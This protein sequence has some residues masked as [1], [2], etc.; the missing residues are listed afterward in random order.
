MEVP[1]G[2]DLKGKKKE[3]CLKLRNN[4]YG[5]KQAGRVW[6]KHLNKGLTKLGFKVS[7]VDPCVYYH[8]HAVFMLY[9][10]DGIFAGPSKSEIAMLIKRMQAEFTVT[11]EGDIKEY[12]GVLVERQSDGTLK[13]SQPQ[14]I[15]QILED[16][17][18]NSRTKSKPTPAPGGQLLEREIDSEA[19]ED[20]FHYRSVIG[21]ANFLEKSTRLDIAVAVHQC[22]RFSSEPKQSHADAVRYFGRYLQGTQDEGLILDPKNDKL[23][24]CWVNA[25]FLGQYVK[26]AQDLALDSMTAKSRTGFIITYA[27]CPITWGSR[28]QQKAT[29]SSTESEYVALSEAFRVLLPMMDLLEEAVAQGVPVELGPPVIHCKAFEDNSGALQ[30]ARLPKMRPRTR[31][32]AVKYHHFREAVAKGRISIQH[33]STDKQLADVLTKNLARDQFLRLR[34]GVMGW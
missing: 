32:I 18:F 2:F 5:T 25:D 31:H 14:L 20:D 7:A 1:V 12:L 8:G 9:I 11:D 3:F 28:I 17:W 4:I 6:N 27:G 13:L 21:K 33:V 23:F 10:D 26:G 30:L 24:E 22:A 34:K 15:K 16:L 29:L 19:M